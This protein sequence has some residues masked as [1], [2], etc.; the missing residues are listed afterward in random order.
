MNETPIVEALERETPMETPAFYETPMVALER[1]TPMVA[2]AMNELKYEAPVGAL[3]MMSAL[4]LVFAGDDDRGALMMAAGGG[5]PS[6]KQENGEEDENECYV[7]NVVYWNEERGFGFIEDPVEQGAKGIF[8]HLS[9]V[10][11]GHN[12]TVGDKVSFRAEYNAVKDRYNAYDIEDVKL[13]PEEGDEYNDEGEDD[14]EYYDAEEQT[15][16]EDGECDGHYMGRLYESEIVHFDDL[17]GFGYLKGIGYHGAPDIF[18]HRS[19]FGQDWEDHTPEVGEEVR[20]MLDYNEEKDR[21]EAVF[22]VGVYD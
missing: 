2:P 14:D 13:Y 11:T 8:F 19:W 5:E 6:E 17:R 10:N 15:G 7:S 4:P 18:F 3:F 20:F 1:E 16:Y 21:D 22:V 12:P 9:N